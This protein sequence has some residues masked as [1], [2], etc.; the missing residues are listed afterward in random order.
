MSCFG[1]LDLF[2]FESTQT[3]DAKPLNKQI[4]KTPNELFVQTS[5]TKHMEELADDVIE[6]RA[7]VNQPQSKDERSSQLTAEPRMHV[8]WCRTCC[9]SLH[10]PNKVVDIPGD[11][12]VLCFVVFDLL[13]SCP[14]ALHVKTVSILLNVSTLR[15]NS[16]VCFSAFC[17]I[18][19]VW[20][21]RHSVQTRRTPV[22]R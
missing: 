11:E 12:V 1:W 22:P 2:L 3:D 18:L 4:L 16:S 9:R 17:Q 8:W 20:Q 7:A 13:L 21:S 14:V 19:A 5:V 15:W 10:H 6:D